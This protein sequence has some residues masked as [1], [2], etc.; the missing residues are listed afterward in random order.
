[1]G[2]EYH[3]IP[4]FVHTLQRDLGFSRLDSFNQCSELS[5]ALACTNSLRIL[6][7]SLEYLLLSSAHFGYQQQLDHL[8]SSLFSWL[9]ISVWLFSLALALRSGFFEVSGFFSTFKRLW[10]TLLLPIVLSGFCEAAFWLYDL[11]SVSLCVIIHLSLRLT[12]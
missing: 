9:W 10:N 11:L 1:M 4:L 12:L 3:L 5:W 7:L 8:I 2:L 6:S